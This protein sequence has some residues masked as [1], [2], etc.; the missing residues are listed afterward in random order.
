MHG[1]IRHDN[2]P[3]QKKSAPVGGRDPKRGLA[4]DAPMSNGIRP[5]TLADATSVQNVS[6]AAY[7]AAYQAALGYVPK[8]GHEDYRPRIARGDD[9]V[10]EDASSGITGVLV[11]ERHADPLMIYSLVIYSLAVEPARENS[12]IGKALLAFADRFARRGGMAE[13]RLFTNKRMV[14]TISLYQRC[15]FVTL[16]ERPHP[17]RAEEVLVDMAKILK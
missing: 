2:S 15:G 5:A 13:I 14:N 9:F 12:G 1:N 10:A 7:T 17:S 8:P 3:L 11:L 6:L 4:E 16:R